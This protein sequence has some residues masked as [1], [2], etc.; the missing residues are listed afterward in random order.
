M[1]WVRQPATRA[2]GPKKRDQ[3]RSPNEGAR[4]T[5]NYDRQIGGLAYMDVVSINGKSWPIMRCIGTRI[6]IY[7]HVY[8][9][10][11][12]YMWV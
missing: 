3:P 5:C 10:I 9:Y 6:H 12:I 11:Y 8:V 1:N 2:G 7:M 4:L